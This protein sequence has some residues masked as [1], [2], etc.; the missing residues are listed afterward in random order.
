MAVNGV[1][2]YFRAEFKLG[3]MNILYGF[4]LRSTSVDPM[5]ALVS[6]SSTLL[7]LLREGDV[8]TMKYYSSDRSM[9]GKDRETRI[10]YI[11]MFPPGR[12]NGHCMIG[13]ETAPAIDQ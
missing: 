5:F 1:A 10:T 9:P 13:L 4:K 12:F 8:I 11:R 3:D 2:G 6:P 7:K